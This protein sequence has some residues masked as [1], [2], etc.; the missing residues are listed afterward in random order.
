MVTCTQP[1]I[2]RI[3]EKLTTLAAYELLRFAYSDLPL[4]QNSREINAPN[5]ETHE[6]R[7]KLS[8]ENLSQSFKRKVP[9]TNFLD[10]LH[11]HH[12]FE[13]Q[14]SKNKTLSFIELIRTRT[15]FSWYFGVSLSILGLIIVS[16]VLF[17]IWKYRYRVQ[18][19]HQTKAV[20]SPP[21]DQPLLR[22][23]G[24]GWGRN[25]ASSRRN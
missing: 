9:E 14:K 8:Y 6:R 17:L 19:S 23:G 4:N 22:V 13:L 25:G 7:A 1:T 24:R 21:P 2:F 16:A 18:R 12:Q 3:K 11:K 15:S 5:L 10:M 20:D